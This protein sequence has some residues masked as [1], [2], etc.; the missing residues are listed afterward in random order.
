MALMWLRRN[1]KKIHAL[2]K[3]LK[4]ELLKPVSKPV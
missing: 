4:V 2:N 3:L 1:E